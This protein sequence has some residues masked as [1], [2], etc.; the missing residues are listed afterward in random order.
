MEFNRDTRVE[1]EFAKQ[2]RIQVDIGDWLFDAPDIEFDQFAQ[3]ISQRDWSSI[4]GSDVELRPLTRQQGFQGNKYI[5]KFTSRIRGGSNRTDAPLIDGKLVLHRYRAAHLGPT[6]YRI[7]S[8][9]SV[10]PTR[11]LAHQPRNQ[12]IINDFLGRTEGE[13]EIPQPEMRSRRLPSPVRSERAINPRDD[14]VLIDRPW[15]MMA[16]PP[17]WQNF[18]N[19]YFVE[20][21]RFLHELITGTFQ[22]SDVVGRMRF[23]WQVNLKQIETYWEFKTPD[24]VRMM[25]TLQPIFMALGQNARHRIYEGVLADNYTD[26]NVPVLTTRLRTGLT[27]TIYPKTTRRLRLELT[28]NLQQRDVDE[29]GHVFDDRQRA[30]LDMLARIDLVAEDAVTEANHLLESLTEA[31]PPYPAPEPPYKL[32]S[33][34]IRST[35]N[36]ADQELLLSVLVN[37]GS[38]RCAS[39]DRLRPAIMHLI[40]RRVLR[41]ASPR[42]QTFTL[43]AEYQQARRI[44]AG[45]SDES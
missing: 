23:D 15:L 41:R 32:V 40:D 1:A 2:D 8:A 44:L 3:L 33:E 21:Y 4:D 19:R 29:G 17:Y 14:N 13:A 34:I 10:N 38:Y 45:H 39:G 24:P 36:A 5:I 26:G 43:T 16:T 35:N 42:R 12:S 22:D 31:L 25:H 18:R 7:V 6:R 11:A 30:L 28:H 9:L 20:I 37:N 27:A